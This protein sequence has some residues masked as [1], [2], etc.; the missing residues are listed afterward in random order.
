[1]TSLFILELKKKKP[2]V[3]S[4]ASFANVGGGEESSNIT[5]SNWAIED[6]AREIVKMIDPIDKPSRFVLTASSNDFQHPQYSFHKQK[7]R[8][9]LYVAAPVK[10]GAL[11]I[12]VSFFDNHG[13]NRGR[14]SV[15]E[16]ITFNREDI[17]GAIA[18]L[19][20][21]MSSGNRS[22]GL[23]LY[24]A[25]GSQIPKGNVIKATTQASQSIAYWSG[26][27]PATAIKT[28]LGK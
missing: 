7:F 22:G 16:T 17:E 2:L 24:H 11:V 19:R 26:E 25:S 9:V 6:L 1:L 27:D 10:Y 5:S 28:L 15:W 18:F 20:G 21:F 4:M 13:N 12:Q 8:D 14:G 3:Q 23:Y